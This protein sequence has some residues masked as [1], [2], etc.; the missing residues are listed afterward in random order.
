MTTKRKKSTSTRKGK[1]RGNGQPQATTMERWPPS[2][3]AANGG[4]GR[5]PRLDAQDLG[6]PRHLHVADSNSVGA[7][8]VAD[9]T[10]YHGSVIMLL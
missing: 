10:M 3:I 2:T 5:W 8:A 1:K 4:R 6:E 7:V 9:S